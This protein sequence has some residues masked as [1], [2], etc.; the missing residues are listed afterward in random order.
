M[1][2]ILKDPVA[3]QPINHIRL[4]YFYNYWKQPFSHY[5]FNISM[6]KTAL[7]SPLQDW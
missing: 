4:W 2:L 5:L 1:Y 3:G 6:E 7:P